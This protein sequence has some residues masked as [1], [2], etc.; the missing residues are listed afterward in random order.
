MDITNGLLT[1]PKMTIESTLGHFEIS[2]TQDLQLN[3][4]YFLKIPWSIIKQGARNKV[5]GTKQGEGKALIEDEIIEVDP[6]R[7]TK[8]LNLKIK[9][10]L[11]DYKITLG[12]QKE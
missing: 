10:N 5:I 8:Y 12:K 1:I 6:K 11:E 4:E 9:G 2:G 7:K 3:M